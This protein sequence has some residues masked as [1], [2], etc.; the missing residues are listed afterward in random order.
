MPET[1]KQYRAQET[2]WLLIMVVKIMS[3]SEARKWKATQCN[4]ICYHYL[5]SVV[6]LK[7]QTGDYNIKI[8]PGNH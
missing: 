2:R 6:T 1:T 7:P 3:S 5:R 8:L 4:M